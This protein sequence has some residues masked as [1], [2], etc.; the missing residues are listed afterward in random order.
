MESGTATFS[1]LSASLSSSP[2]GDR[3]RNIHPENS[4]HGELAGPHS[5]AA[6][7]ASAIGALPRFDRTRLLGLIL[8]ILILVAWEA[9]TRFK[10]M[11]P[12]FLPTPQ[13]TLAA[14]STLIE[15]GRLLEDFL[16]SLRVVT[17][18]F[19]V[20]S[21]LALLL[22]AYCGLS[23]SV[24]RFFGPTLDALRQIPP[25]AWL[26]LLV[27]WV[28]VG[29][30]AKV[31]VIAKVVFFPVFLNTLQG[32]RGVQKE[33]VE[34]AKVFRLTRQQLARKVIIPGALPSIL[35]G[36]R[37]GAGLSWSLVV[38]AEMLSGMKGLGF[39]IWRSQELLFTDQLI[40]V[41]FIIGLFGFFLDRILSLAERRL[42]RWKQGYAG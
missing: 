25:M 14:L 37:Y 36:I 10:L 41:I 38:V 13:R 4:R 9:A 20:G 17:F 26:P 32:I 5:V 34:V 16:E 35:I 22:G 39:L 40:V 42:L 23:R 11:S 33:Y 3:E 19:A 24:E 12:V 29:D 8:P 6:A 15:G 1:A 7:P 28:G 21:G 30:T 31:I 27:L 18:G 2:S